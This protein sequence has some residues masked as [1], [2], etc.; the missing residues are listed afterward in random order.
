M[1]DTIAAG[2]FK[3]KC[4]QLLDQVARNREE[5]TITKRG[6]AVARLVPVP[7]SGPLFGALK[8]TVLRSGD[9]LSPIDEPWELDA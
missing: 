5:L 4:L 3:A 7:E 9:L 8:G 2:E 6:R 1:R